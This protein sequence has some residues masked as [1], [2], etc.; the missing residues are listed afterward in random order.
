M[1]SQFSLHQAKKQVL[2]LSSSP[3]LNER[4]SM[5]VSLMRPFGVY[6]AMA[7][8]GAGTTQRQRSLDEAAETTTPK[9]CG[10]AWPRR[11]GSADLA[12]KGLGESAHAGEE[13]RGKTEPFS[14]VD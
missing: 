14:P 3:P 5:G 6:Q 9:R 7:V 10:G 2:L 4:T 8:G 11:G 12:T 1:P 13:E